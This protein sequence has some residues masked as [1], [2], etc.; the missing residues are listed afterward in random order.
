MSVPCVCSSLNLS[1]MKWF[2]RIDQGHLFSTPNTL[3]IEFDF[4][5]TRVHR[6][7]LGRTTLHQKFARNLA[8]GGQGG[9]LA[10]W[11]SKCADRYHTSNQLAN[12]GGVRIYLYRERPLKFQ[13]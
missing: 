8:L 5:Y 12:I 11:Q 7:F 2:T 10:V 3:I 13:S 9:S 1:G 6:L 4:A